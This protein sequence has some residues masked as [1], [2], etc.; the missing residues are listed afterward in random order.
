MKMFLKICVIFSMLLISRSAFAATAKQ[1]KPLPP[2]FE[3]SGWIPYW[4]SA[5]GTAEALA[6]ASV[7]TELSPFG[8]TV[9][10]DGT[11]FDALKLDQDPWPQ[12]IQTARADGIKLIPTVMWSNAE[13]MDAVLRSATSRKAHIASIVSEVKARGWDGV[14]IDYEAKKSETKIYFSRFLKELKA[15]LG[16]KK[17][18]SCTIEART[19]LDSRYTTPPKTIEYANDYAA[20]GTY[21]DRVRIMAYDQ[22][23]I[24]LKL[25]KTAVGPYVPVADPAWVEKVIRLA[26]KSIPKKKIVLGVATYGYEYTVTPVVGGGYV[27]DRETAFNQNYATGIAAAF[28]LSPTRT[29]TGEMALVYIP[30]S[31]PLVAHS[32][33]G[34]SAVPSQ[35]TSSFGVST[36]TSSTGT[37]TLQTAAS[38]PF[39]LLWW[40]DAG[41]ISDKIALAKRLG[42]RG[43]ALFKLDGGADPLLWNI[44]K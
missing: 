26:M 8:Y 44:L 36:V 28:G 30:T 6:H 37:T 42:L 40:S 15:S 3:I 39:R 27:Y 22:G 13:D 14:D 17:I 20:I 19:P 23:T 12:F 32:L 35:D 2:P 1:V 25:N 21:C 33:A 9:K 43:V 34:T 38:L 5:T 7:F 24:D 10:H 29:K 31:T 16:S 41:A 11:I 4:R 18:L